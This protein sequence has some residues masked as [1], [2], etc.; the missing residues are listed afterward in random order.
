MKGAMLYGR[1]R[2]SNLDHPEFLPVFEADNG[3]G[4]AWGRATPYY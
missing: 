4:M 2:A 1:I 3:M